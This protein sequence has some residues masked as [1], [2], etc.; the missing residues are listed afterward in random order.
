MKLVY[1]VPGLME[2]EELKRRGALLQQWA[3][4][5]TQIDICCVT[6]GPG[7]IESM[8]EEYLSIPATGRLV[9][10]KEKEGYDA[11][12]LGC[13]GDPG[14][15]AMR[16]ITTK[17]L[18]VGP[19]QASMITAAMLGHQFSLITPE[20]SMIPS[21]Y[22]LAFK[23]GVREK[24]ASVVS[25]DIPVLELREKREISIK[26]MMEVGREAI[27]KDRADSLVLGC[28][29]MGFLNVAE[30][31]EAEL[32]VPVINP[33]KV[34][35]KIAEALVATNLMHSKNAFATPSKISSGR[36]KKLEDLYQKTN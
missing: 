12:I 15:D 9:F 18:V 23:A 5:G 25:V 33:S 10:E 34:S 6:E 21:S 24:L 20:K 7:S 28:M 30:E 1:V 19:G 26:K 36:V 17:M 32:G 11:A 16:E 31:M 29:S 13:A 27:E 3:F 2:E 35:L 8:Y 4:S 14:L 22:E